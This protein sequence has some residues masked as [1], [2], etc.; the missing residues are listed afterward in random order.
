M[1]GVASVAGII[2]GRRLDGPAVALPGR[3]SAA[4]TSDTW[5]T[6]LGIRSGQMPRYVLSGRPVAAGL[7]GGITPAGTLASVAGAI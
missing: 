4:A 1:V 6:E 2:P 7:S 5:A 3:Q